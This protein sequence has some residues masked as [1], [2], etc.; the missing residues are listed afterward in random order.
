MTKRETPRWKWTDLSRISQSM[1]CRD[2]EGFI[3]SPSS[4][5]YL[6]RVNVWC[7]AFEIWI[8]WLRVGQNYNLQNLHNQCFSCCYLNSIELLSKNNYIIYMHIFTISVQWNILRNL[9]KHQIF[10]S[11]SDL[12]C[13]S[14]DILLYP[15]RLS[16]RSVMILVQSVTKLVES[17][18]TSGKLFHGLNYSLRWSDDKLNQNCEVN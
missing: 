11:T 18:Q 2:R 6:F 12:F 4:I 7:S 13:L 9:R 10:L 8:D 3:H 5:K 14:A 16:C 1:N 17:Q 15:G